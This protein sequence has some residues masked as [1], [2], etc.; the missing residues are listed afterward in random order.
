[1]NPHSKEI[2]RDKQ[3]IGFLNHHEDKEPGLVIMGDVTKLTIA[4]LKEIVDKHEEL[5]TEDKQ[6]V[7]LTPD[8]LEQ[9]GFKVNDQGDYTKDGVTLYSGHNEFWYW[10]FGKGNDTKLFTVGDLDKFL[11][12]LSR[13]TK[14]SALTTEF[15]HIRQT[16][17]VH[18][19]TSLGSKDGSDI[20]S[21]VWDME[22]TKDLD[23]YWYTCLV[24]TKT[25]YWIGYLGDHQGEA[26]QE[27]DCRDIIEAMEA[28]IKQFKRYCKHKGINYEYGEGTQEKRHTDG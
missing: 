7:R 10:N 18:I 4:E 26:Y 28:G 19:D 1:M 27:S 13:L 20:S 24:N 9:R 6:S 21:S 12:S 16:Y 25:G 2:Y 22:H 5:I 11:S 3:F 17:H 23:Y 15:E 8:V 14:L